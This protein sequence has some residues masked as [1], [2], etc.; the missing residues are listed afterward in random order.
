MPKNFQDKSVIITGASTG[1]GRALAHELAAQGAVVYV[2]AITLNEAQTV[3]AEIKEQGGTS[4]AAKCDVTID[5]DIKRVI[6]KTVKEQGQLD[7]MINNAGIIFIGEFFDMNEAQIRKLTDVNYNGVQIG[8]LHAY[9]QMKQQGFGQIL[10]IASMGGLLP[11]PSMVSYAGTKFGVVGLTLSLATEAEVFGVD[12]RA[13]CLGNVKSN[14]MTQAETSKQKSPDILQ[15]LPKQQPTHITARNIVKGL[16]K[17]D[18]LIFTPFYAKVAWYLMRLSPKQ[19]F[20]G[21]QNMMDKYRK[22]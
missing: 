15:I 8:M 17:K 20:K 2:T 21:S 10:N 16:L 7:L 6:K 9:R 1:I 14:L 5:G 22:L 12:L 19:L 4:F 18:R 13:A 3:A 11:T